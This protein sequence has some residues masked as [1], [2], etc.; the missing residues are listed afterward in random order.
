MSKSCPINYKVVDGNVFR[1]NAAVMIML[2][3][4]FVAMQQP[5][6]LG[7][8]LADLVVKLT[9][10]SRFSPLWQL[11]VALQKGFKVPSN[12]VDAGAKRLAA[13]FA[14]LFAIVSMGLFLF[15]QPFALLF[16]VSVW[17][18]FAFLEVAFDLCVGCRIYFLFKC[19]F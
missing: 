19:V 2:L 18:F 6:F 9:V 8:I 3:V 7:I 16:V 13:I 15:N 17:V 1:I 14:L 11:S 12:Y 10:G 4:L 5:L